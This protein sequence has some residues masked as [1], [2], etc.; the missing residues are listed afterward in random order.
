[1][2]TAPPDSP[3]FVERLRQGDR[4]AFGELVKTHHNMLLATARTLL[5][6]ADAEEAVQDAWIAAHRAIARFEGRSQLRTWLTRIVINQARMMLRRGGREIQFDPTD[7]QDALAHRFRADGHWQQAPRQWELAGPDALLTREE[8][9]RCMEKT[10]GRMPDN[11]RLVLELRDLQGM[12]F[13][14][15]CNML[16]VSAS[17]VR[18]LLHRARA[19]LFE[20]VDHFQETGEC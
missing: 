1:M 19:R 12:E 10:L 11:Q 4:A 13:D 3:D 6:P 5:S 14:D 9:R 16:D 17:N 8:L 2:P 18:V 15:I 20:L 7:E